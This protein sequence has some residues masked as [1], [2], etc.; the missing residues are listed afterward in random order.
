MRTTVKSAV[1]GVILAAGLAFPAM[2]QLDLPCDSFERD[3]SG[4]WYAMQQVTVGTAIGLIEV[5]PGN[6]VSAEVANVLDAVCQ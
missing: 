1:L 3:D 2:A 6:P 5:M 4:A